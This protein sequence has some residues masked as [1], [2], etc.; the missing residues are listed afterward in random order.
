[1]STR[2][3]CDQSTLGHATNSTG[4]KTPNQW[5][6]P[7]EDFHCEY[8]ANYVGV[9]TQCKLTI[10]GADRRILTDAMLGCY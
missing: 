1:M 7:S 5:M 10:N 3:P 9:S 2:I 6:P 4:A 8:A